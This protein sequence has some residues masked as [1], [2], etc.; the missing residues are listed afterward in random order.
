[1][2]QHKAHELPIAG[3]EPMTV[4]EGGQSETDK[5]Y[6]KEGIT[7]TEHPTDDSP[8]WIPQPKENAVLAAL[9]D[10]DLYQS[11]M[12][13]GKHDITCPWV[14][15]HSGTVEAGAVYFEPGD[16]WPTGGF[17]C[18]HSSCVTRQIKDLLRLLDVEAADARMKP[19]IRIRVGEVHRVVDAA[20]QALT[21]S[22]LYYQRGGHI[23][24]VVTDPA[25]LETRVQEVSSQALVSALSRVTNWEKY[26]GRSKDW[27][28]TDPPGRHVNVLHDSDRYAHLP[29][30]N[31][32]ARHPYLRQDGSLMTEAG[33]DPDSGMFGVF[34]ASEYSVPK[35][36]TPKDA[37]AAL[38]QLKDLLVEFSLGDGNDLAAALSAIITGVTRPSLPKAPMFHVRAHMPGSGKSYLCELITAFTTPKRGT[39]TNFPKGDEECQKLLL[40]ELLR[41]PAVI[42]FDNLTSDL[43]A[44]KSLCTALTSEHLSGRILGASKTATV[45]TRALFLSSGN[46]VGPIQDM[47]RRCITINLDPGCETPATRAFTRP[48]LVGDVL[49]E[50]GHY[51]SAALTIVRAWVVANRPMVNC[52][53]I[54]GVDDWSALCRQPLLW[55]GMADPAESV[56]RALSEDPDRETLGWLLTA[57]HAVFGNSPTLV[58]DAVNASLDQDEKSAELQEV[59]QEI[60]EE[61]GDINRRRLGH[62]IKSRTGR[63]VDGLK[64]VKSASKRSAVAWQV[65]SV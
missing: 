15:E 36:P 64:F 41:A 20:E 33:Y 52:K 31:G 9:R 56:F 43:L 48:N 21:Q 65:Q 28:L 4:P 39:P 30:L 2:N 5:T 58:R 23:V 25:T 14:K 8:V 45:S 62:W 27:I 22:G 54:A 53:N 10:R 42:E 55:L 61:R 57:W 51:I 26:D 11:P 13:D 29:V 1:M 18:H 47:S 24:T 49:S 19:T 34:D 59:L 60:A 63:I 12:G 44:H 7:G 38:A 3:T 46:N 40:A 50:R 6:A 16:N 17:K 37:E 32:I 35:N